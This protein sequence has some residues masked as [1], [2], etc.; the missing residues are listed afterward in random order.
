MKLKNERIV[1][2]EGKYA[3]ITAEYDSDVMN[4]FDSR[5][6]YLET[7]KEGTFV[8]DI[9]ELSALSFHDTVPDVYRV[10]FSPRRKMAKVEKVKEEKHAV[11][12]AKAID[13]IILS[14][15]D[16]EK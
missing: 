5:C 12:I 15:T 2:T 14:E 1:G 16:P 10:I 9:E 11:A 7:V 3:L 8:V 4:A 13:E 6:P